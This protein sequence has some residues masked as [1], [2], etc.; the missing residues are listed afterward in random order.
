MPHS[1]LDLDL[2]LIFAHGVPAYLAIWQW[3]EL[4]TTSLVPCS[5]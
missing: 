5:R 1:H 2:T 4:M 3:G